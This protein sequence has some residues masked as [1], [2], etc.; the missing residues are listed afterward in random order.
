MVLRGAFVC[1]VVGLLG[2]AIGGCCQ[3]VECGWQ[4]WWVGWVVQREQSPAAVAQRVGPHNSQH[5]DLKTLGTT[6]TLV[7]CGVLV[8]VCPHPVS[9][10]LQ[11]V[12]CVLL[13]TFAHPFTS[14]L[15]VFRVRVCAHTCA[16]L[17]FFSC[18]SLDAE[19]TRARRSA[20]L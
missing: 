17:L 10:L 13:A 1:V 14:H 11:V 19:Q 2:A 20:Y 8:C 18:N 4:W 5:A 6:T 16:V 15:L 9:M 12:P 7:S 3:C